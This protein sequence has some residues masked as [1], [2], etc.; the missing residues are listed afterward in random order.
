MSNVRSFRRP[1]HCWL[2]R[3]LDPID[4][5]GQP[6]GSSAHFSQVKCASRALRKLSEPFPISF[7]EKMRCVKFWI[8]DIMRGLRAFDPDS[9]PAQTVLHART[10]RAAKSANNDTKSFPGVVLAEVHCVKG[11]RTCKRAPLREHIFFNNSR[12]SFR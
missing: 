1:R 6:A 2:A 10:V 3:I 9:R 11:A 7:G 5:D 4:V 8:L 12:S